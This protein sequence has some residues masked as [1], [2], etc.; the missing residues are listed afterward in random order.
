MVVAL[1]DN[2]VAV[3]EVSLALAVDLGFHQSARHVYAPVVV[4]RGVAVHD[5]GILDHAT[6]FCRELHE[7]KHCI[8]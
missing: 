8:L 2:F 5:H 3:V 6:H 1:H 7:R 4:Q